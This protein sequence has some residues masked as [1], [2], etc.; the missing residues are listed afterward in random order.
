MA[1][2]KQVSGKWQWLHSDTVEQITNIAIYGLAVGGVAIL[3]KVQVMQ[4]DNQM[5]GAF[6]GL[7]SGYVIDALRR[8]SKDNNAKP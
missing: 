8:W 1:D 6:V 4:F 5:S 7:A 2:E 3:E